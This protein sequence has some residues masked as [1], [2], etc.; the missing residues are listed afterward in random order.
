M[1]GYDKAAQVAKKAVKENK[2][3]KEVLKAEKLLTDEIEKLLD[4]KSML[5]PK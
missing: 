5:S 2:T 1:I 3:I 4:P